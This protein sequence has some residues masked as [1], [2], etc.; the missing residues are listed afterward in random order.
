[1]GAEATLHKRTNIVGKPN[2]N[3]KNSLSGKTKDIVHSL[4]AFKATDKVGG[5][6]THGLS[7]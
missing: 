6:F 4:A 1:V 2:K 5:S 7:A 3:L